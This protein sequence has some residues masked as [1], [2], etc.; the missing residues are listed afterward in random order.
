M[1]FVTTKNIA[2]LLFAV[3]VLAG[4]AV[5]ARPLF[6]L[7]ADKRNDYIARQNGIA[8]NAALEAYS[9]K[10]QGAFPPAVM[11]GGAGDILLR[12]KIMLR[13]PENP[14]SPGA[15]SRKVP[16]GDASSGDFS[17]YR[18]D[19]K[20]YEYKFAVYGK[21]GTVFSYETKE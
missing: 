5:M 14:F 4:A 19:K 8:I 1:K 16:F 7:S 11:I 17:Y 18:D 2:N 13:Y 21:H 12:E 9:E 3:A 6:I 10:H 15:S 20:T